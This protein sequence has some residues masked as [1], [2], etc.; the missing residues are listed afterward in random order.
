M[1]DLS[2]PFNFVGPANAS[3]PVTTDIQIIPG[4]RYMGGH[5]SNVS[6]N[7]RFIQFFDKA[8]APATGDVP[9][10]SYPVTSLTALDI[11]FQEGQFTRGFTNGIVI[12]GSAAQTSF[13]SIPST[14]F[15]MDSQYS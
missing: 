13:A 11:Q 15:L 8:A 12:V 2:T 9:I 6:A 4:R 1:P 3:T 10:R 7:K 5:Y 14:E